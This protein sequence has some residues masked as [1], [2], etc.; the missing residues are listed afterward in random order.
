[1]SWKIE[2]QNKNKKGFRFWAPPPYKFLDTRLASAEFFV[3]GA[4]PK[5]ALHQKE[6]TQFTPNGVKKYPHGEKDTP[7]SGRAPPPPHKMK[8]SPP[9]GE[10][11]TH[12]EKK[13]PPPIEL[14]FA[15]Y[16]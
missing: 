13:A 9:R 5:K 1:M 6:K 2:K 10:K 14:N 4:S 11:A 3:G 15:G 8:K 7:H 16:N 12:N